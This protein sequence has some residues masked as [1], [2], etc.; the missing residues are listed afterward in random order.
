MRSFAP[1]VSRQAGPSA[2]LSWTAPALRS[3]R[4]AARGH[5]SGVGESA[6]AARQEPPTT[7][8]LPIL[9][10]FSRITIHAAPPAIQP[11]L[12]IGASGDAREREADQVAE[13]VM[14]MPEPRLQTGRRPSDDAGYLEAPAA[15]HDVLRSPG[16]PLDASTRAFMEPRFGHDFSRVRVHTDARA[17]DSAQAVNARAYTVGQHIVFGKQA[18]SPVEPAGRTLLAHELVHTLQQSGNVQSIQPSGT[19][20]RRR[21]GNF[22]PIGTGSSVSLMRQTSVEGTE[23]SNLTSPVFAGIKE[24]EMVFDGELVIGPGASGEFVRRIQIALLVV[25]PMALP[26]SGPDGRYGPETE[27][28]VKRYQKSHCLRRDV[29]GKL[30]LLMPDGIVGR[31][32]MGCLDRWTPASAASLVGA[33]LSLDSEDAYGS[34]KDAG[35]DLGMDA[36]LLILEKGLDLGAEKLTDRRVKKGYA[37]DTHGKVHKLTRKTKSGEPWPVAGKR[38]RGKFTTKNGPRPYSNTAKGMKGTS[39]FIG[40]ALGPAMD[41]ADIGKVM[42]G[43]VSPMSKIVDLLVGGLPLSMVVEDRLAEV[44][45]QLFEAAL[46]S[47]YQSAVQYI[48]NCRTCRKMTDGMSM[49]YVTDPEYSAALAGQL[50]MTESLRKRIL[51]VFQQSQSGL[52]SYAKLAGVQAPLAFAILLYRIEASI[53]KTVQPIAGFDVP[54]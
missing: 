22:S 3:V 34:V 9:H 7:P 24:L 20:E 53:G 36:G 10:D 50:V 49:L 37:V 6:E 52:V 14:R 5:A 30:T 12:R 54:P 45:D 33:S 16:H 19:R 40:E 18:F 15:V 1:Q 11:K 23:A 51:P 29:H 32:T 25:D 2:Q 27:A 17:A 35:V 26:E 38:K 47:G 8:N 46:N 21:P 13:Q 31:E 43:E 48:Q 39:K 42:T 28:A 4:T 41:M 44:D